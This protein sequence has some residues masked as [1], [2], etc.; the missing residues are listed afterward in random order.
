MMRGLFLRGQLK[1]TILLFSD[2]STPTLCFPAFRCFVWTTT[3]T[4]LR[5]SGKREIFSPRTARQCW[6]STAAGHLLLLTGYFLLSR[7]PLANLRLHTTQ[8]TTAP[9]LPL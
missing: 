7:A 2:F 6:L 5:V 8:A 1:N 4:R 9:V 3:C